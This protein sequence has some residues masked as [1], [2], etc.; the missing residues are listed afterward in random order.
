MIATIM[1]KPLAQSSKCLKLLYS[2]RSWRERTWPFS[3]VT[4]ENDS[5]VAVATIFT[6][7]QPPKGEGVQVL[8]NDFSNQL[9]VGGRE[10]IDNFRTLKLYLPF[11]FRPRRLDWGRCCVVAIVDRNCTF[12]V[13]WT[14]PGAR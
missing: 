4:R 13:R 1:M 3:T 7:P 12:Q 10:K 9:R 6:D 11:F 8:R 2:S 14:R 5:Y